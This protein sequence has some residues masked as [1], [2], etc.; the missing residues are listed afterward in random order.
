MCL[1]GT[2]LWFWKED[3]DRTSLVTAVSHLSES[4]T[5][6]TFW[7]LQINALCWL[8]HSDMNFVL[9]WMTAPGLAFIESIFGIA[10][11][12]RTDIQICPCC[13]G[14]VNFLLCKWVW[15]LALGELNKVAP[16]RVGS[17][18]GVCS[19][20]IPT[21]DLLPSREGTCIEQFWFGQNLYL[22]IVCG[23][24]DYWQFIWMGKC[25]E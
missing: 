23:T 11:W 19:C 8:A 12:Q 17:I 6:T 4:S 7:W 15:H 18:R 21:P 24:T 10:L 14:H 3:P 20:F 16:L 5:S 22:W 13:L 9:S 2:R 1:N 25:S